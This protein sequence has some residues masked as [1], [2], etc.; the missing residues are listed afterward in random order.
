MKTKTNTTQSRAIPIALSLSVLFVIGIFLTSPAQKAPQVLGAATVTKTATDDATVWNGSPGTNYGTITTNEAGHSG[1]DDRYFAVKFQG[2]DLPADATI[3][4]ATVKLTKATTCTGSESL[5]VL[6]ITEDWAENTI[7]YNNKPSFSFAGSAT[8][9]SSCSDS[10]WTFDATAIV[11]AWKAG[12]PN[13]GVYIWGPYSGSYMK[14][15][16]SSEYSSSARRPVLD[17]AYTTPDPVTPEPE[18]T[19]TPTP[20]ATSTPTGSGSTTTTTTATTST[21][22]GG[23]V[24]KSEVLTPKLSEIQINGTR[25]DSRDTSVTVN[26]DDKLL[27]KGKASANQTVVVTVGDK[28]FTATA[29]AYGDWELEL[30]AADF[31]NGSYEVFAK[32]IS[33]DNKESE[34]IK[35]FEF[36]KKEKEVAK[37]SASTKSNDKNAKLKKYGLIGGVVLL[38]LIIGGT[39]LFLQMRKKKASSAKN[40]PIE[41]K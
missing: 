19:P 15:F 14:K 24:A 2:L 5:T 33:A 26:D 7:S 31:E 18:A 13:Y 20:E 22:G 30:D 9:A 6:R 4:S 36:E 17:I 12:S 27:I 21:P 34:K 10:T 32:A 23:E 29:D 11:N 25:V 39:V 41:K 28:N 35:L 38:V 37:E 8:S 1:T 40:I 3:T 16:W